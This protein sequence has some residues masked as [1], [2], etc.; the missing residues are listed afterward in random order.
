MQL[1][2]LRTGMIF[3]DFWRC[4]R[5]TGRD[6]M[7]RV[8]TTGI[9]MRFGRRTADVKAIAGGK[10]STEYKKYSIEYGLDSIEYKLDSVEYKVYSIEYKL[11]SIEYKVYSVEYKLDSI[12][13]KIYSVEYKLDS[14]EYKIYSTEYST[15]HAQNRP[16]HSIASGVAVW[17]FTMVTGLFSGY[18]AS[19]SK[20]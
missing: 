2:L 19:L 17:I 3:C 14:V 10:Y 8:S 9:A 15:L 5:L 13:Y 18:F 12:E 11:D 7:H 1:V 6:A 16:T 20:I 4:R